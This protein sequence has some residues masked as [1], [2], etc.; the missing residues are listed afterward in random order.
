MV[1]Y[2][3]ANNKSLADAVIAVES[4]NYGTY[5][6]D[7]TTH[8]LY[9][10]FAVNTNGFLDVTDANINV[11][12]NM[13][14]QV[15]YA[16]PNLYTHNVLYTASELA[17][18]LL[19]S[20]NVPLKINLASL[21]INS[22]VTFD[23]FL[24][25]VANSMGGSVGTF[26]VVDATTGIVKT[27]TRSKDA[28][29][30]INSVIAAP[31][32]GDASDNL[33]EALPNSSGLQIAAQ[34]NELP[35]GIAAIGRDGRIVNVDDKGREVSFAYDD[36]GNTI[37]MYAFDGFSKITGKPGVTVVTGLKDGKRISTDILINGNDLG[38]D[39]SGFVSI[40]GE[41]LGYRLAGSDKLAGIVLSG[42]LKTFGDNM[43]DVID[44]VVGRQSIKNAVDDAFDTV[45]SELLANLKSAGLGA[46]SSFLTAELIHAL[47][48]GG[49]AGELTN[50]AAGTAIGTIVSNIATGA[51]L[52]SPTEL[53]AGLNPATI[54]VAVGSFLGNKLANEIYAWDT[55][56]G[57][58]GAA[59]GS[60][61]LLAMDAKFFLYAAQTGNAVIIGIAVVA[62]VLDA[63]LGNL[64]GGLI[65]SIFG[66][67]P[68]SG[69]DATWNNQQQ[70]FVVSN[71]W[72][73]KGGSEDAARNI[74]TSVAGALNSILASVGGTLL[75]PTAIQSG[76]Y[77]LIKKDF[78]YRPVGGGSDQGTVT[79]RF[80]GKDAARNLIDYGVYQGLMD[81]DF[82]IAGGDIYTKRAI[83]NYSSRNKSTNSTFNQDVLLGDIS[84]AQSYEKY[85]SNS[86]VIAA[87]IAADPNTVFATET[88][89]TL[90]RA[91][92][93]GL[94]RRAASDWFGGFS[95]LVE[96]AG[97][98]VADVSF[99]FDYDSASDQISRLIGLGQYTLRD[100]IDVAGQTT[101]EGTAVRDVLN[102]HTGSLA[103][104][105]GY[106][107][108]GH[109]NNDIAVT[110]EDFTA[111]TTSVSFAAGDLRK[112][113][114][115]AVANDGVA[116]ATEAFAASLSNA[117]GMQI[118]GGD[119]VVTVVDGTAALATLM[120]GRSY[121]WEGDGYAIFRLSLSKAASQAVTLALALADGNA[122][123][124]GVDYG[125][126]GASNIQV[127]SDGVTWTNATSLSFAVGATERFVRVAVLADNGVD[128]QGKPTNVEGNERFTLTAT[129]TAGAA[130]L[131]NGASPVSGVGTIVD[132][133]GT[134]PLVWIDD[135]TLDE[136]SGQA[137]FTLSRSRTAPSATAVS[138]ATSDRRIFGID[139]AATVD[140]GD[141][142][143]WAQASDLGDNIFGGTGNDTIYGGQL[144]DWLFGGDGNDLI[145]AGAQDGSL[146]GDG[147][148][149]DGGAGN[150]ELNGREGSDWLVGGDGSDRLNGNGGDDILAGGAGNNDILKGGDGADQY[151]VQRGDGLDII[152]DIGSDAPVSSGA[153]DAITQRMAAIE[154]WK[155]NPAAAG[156]IA[157]NWIGTAPGATAGTVTGGEDSI[158]FGAGIDIGDIRLQRSG[159]AGTPGNDLLIKIMTTDAQG[160]ETFSGTQ[161][162]VTD[163]FLNPFKRI[164]WLKFADGN[165]IRIGDITSLVIGGSGNDVLVGTAGNDFVYGGAG[166]D[167]LLLMDG[168]DVGNGGTG[169]DMVSG[170]NGRD[171]VIGGLGNDKLFGG[172]GSD[173]LT[174]DGGADQ[175]YGGA[176]RDVLSG[177][178]GDGDVVV[179][180]AGDDTFKYSRGDGRDIYFDEYANYWQTVWTSGSWNT[181][182]GFSYNTT[183]GEVMGP[184]GVA[185]YKNLGTV[186]AP[187]FDWVGLFDFNS[188]T[189]VLRY[190]NPPANAATITANAGA[191]TIEF[192]PGINLQDVILRRPAGTNDLV[193][194]ISQ[195]NAELGDT[196]SAADSVT[197]RDWYVN[198]GQIEKLAFYQTG[199]LEIAPGTRSLIA[200]SDGADGTTTAALQGTGI[201]DWITGGAGDDVIAGG[202]GNDI[203]AG[204]S[205][206]D[207]LRGE[208]GNDVLYGG[209]G[210]DQLDGGAGADV[211]VGGAG[212]DAASYA[213]ASAAVRVH[214][215]ARGANSGDAVGDEYYGIEN[216]IG[217]GGADM[218]GGDAGDNELT[219]GLGDDT[220]AGNGGDDTYIWNAGDGID[221][222]REGSFV[223][224]EVVTTAGVLAAGYQTSIWADTG[225]INGASGF[226]YWRLQI[227]GP[228]GTIVFDDSTLSYAAGATPAAPSPAS[229]NQAG[230]LGGFKRTN[231]AQ[232]TRERF[233]PAVDG[234]NDTLELGP[235]ISFSSLTF[236][237]SGNDLYITNASGQQIRLIG[238]LLAANRVETLQL[239]DG[240][241]VSLASVMIAPSAAGFYG[242]A[243]DDLIV[244]AGGTTDLSLIGGDGNDVII[245][246]AGADRLWGQNGEDI[247]E[248]GAG[249][250]RLDG[251]GRSA[252]GTVV[253]YGDTVRYVQSSA[254]VSI[255]LRINT[256]QSGGDAQGD[257][258]F[259]ISNVIGSAFDD[260]LQGDAGYNRLSGM[261]GNDTIRGG[262]ADD[263]LLGDAGD[264]TLYGDDGADALSGGLGNDNLY[265]GNGDDRL[266]GG[267]GADNLYGDAGKDTL[268]AGAGDDLL[269]GGTGDDTLVGAAGNDTLVGGDGN[270]MLSGGTGND[271]LSGGLGNDNYLFDATSG[272]DVIVDASGTNLINF[273]QSVSYDRL[274]ITRSGTDLRIAVMGGDTI[275]TLSG[276]YAAT[277][278]GLARAIQTST[279]A[280][281]LDNAN[282]LNLVTAMT[283]QATATPAAMPQAITDLLATYW[284]AGGKAAPTAPST[285]RAVA[286]SE[287]TAIAISGGAY[288]VIDHD[289]GPITYS[290]KADAGPSRGTVTALNAAT[291]AV[292]YTPNANVNGSD[293]FS[294]I[295]TDA[296]GQSVEL[297]VTV[298]IAPVNDL[299][300]AV[301]LQSGALSI[302][303]GGVGSTTG[304]GTAVAQFQSSDVDGDPLTFSLADDAGGRFQISG[305]GALSVKTA[306]SL[307]YEAG[308][309]HSIVI[310]VSDGNGGVTQTGFTIAVTNLNEPLTLPA[311]YSLAVNENVAV[312]TTLGTIVAS[313][314][315]ASSTA[316]GQPRYFFLVG[317]TASAVSSDGRYTIDAVSGV[318][319]TY[320]AIDFE[321]GPASVVHTVIARDNAGNAPFNQTS[322]AVTIGVTN[323]NE[324]NA[325]PASYAMA[326]NENVAIGTVV[327]TVTATDLD[328]TSHVFG[329]QRYYFLNGTTAVSTTADGRYVIDASTGVIKTYAG[330][331]YEAGMP[332]VAYTVIARDNAGNAPFNQASSTVAIGITNQNEAN[333]LPT[334]YAMG[335]NENVAVGTAVG[336]VAATDPDDAAITFGQQ[337]YYFLNGTT[338]SA[339]SSDNR[340][341]IDASTGI[342]KTNS[343]LNYEAG[344]T[345]VAYTVIARD[346]AGNA[347]YYQASSTVTIGIADVNEAPTAMA[348][349]PTAIS[350]AER[351]RIAAGVTRDAIDLTTFTVTDPDAASTPFSTYTYAVSDSRFEFVG[352]I[353]RLKLNA[354]LDYEAASSVVVT[355]TATDTSP[356]HLA[357]ARSVTI[358][359]TNIDDILEGDDNANTLT[360]QKNRDII[361]GYGGNDVIDGGDGY[362]TIYG[363]AGS[364]IIYSGAGTGS[365]L[366]GEDDNDILVGGVGVDYLLGGNNNTGTYDR[367]YGGAGNDFLYGG[368]G[369]DILVGGEGADLLD[370]GNGIDYADY[371]QIGYGVQATEG[372]SVDLAGIVAN[373]GVAVGDTFVGIEFLRGTAFDDALRG[374]AVREL[375][376]G[377][378][379]NDFIDARAGDD[380]LYGGAGND[381]LYG[382]DG[383]DYIR[384]DDGDDV[385][386]GGN[387]NDTL[388]GGAGNDT[389]YAESGNDLLDGG[390]GDDILVGGLDSDTYL[391]SR[392]SGAD[393][394]QNYDPSGTDVDVLGFQDT[395]GVINDKDIWFE[396]SGNDLL[397]SVIGTTSSARIQNWYVTPGID[398]ANYK[399]DYIIAGTR[400]SRTIDV[401]GLVA[402]MATKTKPTTIADQDALLADT[403][404]KAVWATYWRTNAAPTLAA[405]ATQTMAEDGTLVLTVS[406]T[407]DITPAPGIQVSGEILSGGNVIPVSGLVFGAPDNAGNRTLTIRPASNVAGSA[408]IRIRAVDAGGVAS[409]RDFNLSVTPVAD[410]PTIASFVGGQGTSGAPVALTVNV[411]FPDADG[412]ELQELWITGVPTGVT[413]SA[414]T[415][416]SATATWKLTPVQASNLK[417]N[418]PAGWSTD[419]SLTLKARATEG[420]Q[421][422]VATATTTVVLN[423]P[424]TSLSLTGSVNENVANGTAVGMVS[425]VDPDGDV[426]TY[427]LL[428][429][430]GGRF[431]L[432]GAGALTVANGT[433]LNFEAA[434]SHSITVRA[435][436]RFGAIRDQSLTVTVNNV[437]E[438]PY[439]TGF[440]GGGTVAANG[441]ILFTETG[442]GAMP[443]NAD[444]LVAT[445]A[446][447][448]PDGTTPTLEFANNPNNWFYIS[449]NTVRFKP[450][451]NFDYETLINYF[452]PNA[453]QDG[454]GSIDA[455]LG[456]L[457]VRATDGALRATGVLI[458][459]YISNVNE[460]PNVP[461]GPG[462]VYFDETGLGSNP[463]NAGTLLG[464]Y[465][466]LSDPDGTVPTLQLT[467]NLGNWFYL[468]GNSVRFNGG[469][470]FDFEWFRANNYSVNDWNGDGRQ[471]VYLGDV[472]VKAS[473]GTLMSGEKRTQVFISNVNEAPNAPNYGATTWSFADET[474]LGSNPANGGVT[475]ATFSMTDPDGS[476]PVLEFADPS[477][478]GWFNIVGNQVRFNA[479]PNFDFEWF[480]ANNYGIYDWN[481]DGRLDAHIADVRLRSNDGS[482]LS[483]ETLLQVFISDVNERPNAPVME[484]NNIFQETTGGESHSERL[485]TRFGL[486]D[487]DGPTPSLVI[488]SGNDWGWFRVNGQH[489]QIN[490]GVNW[491]ADWLRANKGQHG[492]DADFYTD[493]NG[494]G[495]KEIRVATL[496]VATQDASGALSDPFT[497]N[498]LIED[499]NEAPNWATTPFTFNLNENPG[500]YQQVGTVW[501]SDIDGPTS[502]LRY[503]FSNWDRYLDG[504]LN[505][506]V[507]RSTDQIYVMTESGVV[508][509]NGN[510]AMDYDAA[511]AQRNFSYET[512]I[513]DKAYGANNAYSYGTLNINLQDVNEGHWLNN[514]SVAVN[515]VGSLPPLQP[516]GDLNSGQTIDLNAMMLSDPEARP[517]TMSW[518]FA[519]NSLDS[520]NWHISPQGQLSLRYGSVDYETLASQGQTSVVLG[521]KASDGQNAATGS[522]T[523]NVRDVNEAPWLS[524]GGL[525]T[526]SYTVYDPYMGTPMGV[527]Y[528]T[529]FH[530]DVHDPDST[531]GYS[532]PYNITYNNASAYGSP[533]ATQMG[534]A[535][536]A[537]SVKGT[538]SWG[539][540]AYYN[541]PTPLQVTSGGDY[542][543]YGYYPHVKTTLY[544]QDA[545]GA[546][547]SLNVDLRASNYN[548]P[549]VILDL[550]GDGV[551]LTNWQQTS[552]RFDMNND[553]KR[554]LTSWAGPDDALLGIDLNGNGLID[555]GSEI[556]FQPHLDG[557]LSDLE[558]LRLYDTNANGFIDAGDERFADFRVWQDVNQDGISAPGE[559]KALSEAGIAEINLT[560]T[561]TGNLP[562]G[563]SFEN[564][565]YSTSQYVKT[566]GTIGTIG[567]AF[568]SY[569]ADGES[570]FIHGDHNS[571]IGIDLDGNGLAISDLG[572]SDVAFDIG[573]GGYPLGT[574]W[575]GSGDALLVA[576]VNGNGT[577]DNGI[578]LAVGGQGFSLARL[579]ALDSNHD[580]KV[581]AADDAFA[582]LRLWEDA[583]QDGVSQSGELKTLSETDITALHLPS[584]AT[585]FVLGLGE[586]RSYNSFTVEFGGGSTRQGAELLLAYNSPFASQASQLAQAM[587]VFAPSAGSDGS[588]SVPSPINDPYHLAASAA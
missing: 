577:I 293:S 566:D 355:V 487:P 396:R 80:S 371:S 433:L 281:Y 104:Q 352:N 426:L 321:A 191:D 205:G 448:D 248:G 47:S 473:D 410:M 496:T 207:I 501:G 272:N 177:G 273:D 397:V 212:Q 146:G 451:M 514:R 268:T 346:N 471:E 241:S 403:T 2:A 28:T 423:A 183:T 558:G 24:G 574:A 459:T 359:V 172:A 32:I 167:K 274:W 1:A 127:S 103:D 476:T 409:V 112:Q 38:I 388:L 58:I 312:G 113:V 315:D 157:P 68:R 576:D 484:A 402:L 382:G 128:G 564:V 493:V 440:T 247:L 238:Q 282:S 279:H 407:D 483:G 223:V 289:G 364:D 467:G 490:T 139:V 12:G 295:A 5:L 33:I 541:W 21:S 36:Y 519:D 98:T 111:L 583:N 367:L 307:N 193:L 7:K 3:K 349:T 518:S 46:V 304:T 345:S 453:D 239:A 254:A 101:I 276:F 231:G 49:M 581:T 138:F 358:N 265:G 4:S 179:G 34:E 439:I 567:D 464:T 366:Y 67:T 469:L 260:V 137:K 326:V 536:G 8:N 66:G 504:N 313:D 322:T 344:N 275:V 428:D 228:D 72:S 553:G 547:G 458:K 225:T 278:A 331:N 190:F 338:A 217:S 394:I 503:T 199:I 456:D 52:V 290:L 158:V 73:R 434:Q 384:G 475:V 99:G 255:D 226:H 310:R 204:N 151:L 262:G 568:L 303:E 294:L 22:A 532:S 263:V 85:L 296:D 91:Q 559:L 169:D 399:L 370:G 408:T 491:T 178:R 195:E 108:N 123:G 148:Y 135:V 161:L 84:S 18:L 302:L 389:L 513:Y 317:S 318:I 432:T 447:F 323:L 377:G 170:D 6:V 300:T 298:S 580:G 283:A 95:F 488:L 405:I 222:I 383:A 435:T 109:L 362:D 218:L 208:A 347:G 550:D 17:I 122:T 351:D 357:I 341:I 219:G 221:T 119:A 361:Y 65:G 462:A 246:T 116:E 350:V 372:V 203:I 185:I 29:G 533:T 573:G 544:A 37:A 498:V 114:T 186:Q 376:E 500:W 427:A 74:A 537:P 505:Q 365:V 132:G 337:R 197:I 189:G 450:G 465:G 449:G 523:V 224:E 30:K 93:L 308:T 526:Y 188:A 107:V 23:A 269:D 86:A 258:L 164:E 520:G 454:N 401:D 542:L 563:E 252:Y 412:S 57:Q 70:Q 354:S 106:T 572:D 235:G 441:A 44:G 182:G 184:G 413:L 546:T 391:M 69:A 48:I 100:T 211:L 102:L 540:P 534:W 380:S 457:W 53:F 216:L 63:L 481:G 571:A 232:V 210:N 51:S 250:D 369:D 436:D 424:P 368:D 129:V 14:R 561:P 549:P 271:S 143:D 569:M 393:T 61:V 578:E 94:T 237:I 328:G 126:A 480:R 342:I 529:W 438:A 575:I 144:D 201:A 429:N 236:S 71:V 154:A 584:A 478:A 124:G 174:G 256:E 585:P 234:G 309:S 54:G 334:S 140:L 56:G 538:D 406:A 147:N 266:D 417:V 64:I 13:D 181:A 390:E 230:W 60:S 443:A 416:D 579:A 229:Y 333:A 285:P 379:G 257:T 77:G 110:G 117:P 404:Y 125:S 415:F 510:Q 142:D 131:A 31:A 153:G 463:A 557:A 168:D 166:N 150:D 43:G 444:V 316:F 460:A 27:I 420:G 267:D 259:N 305:S 543:V 327:G 10:Q 477:V 16:M 81:P 509:V 11:A 482:I 442:L 515:E 311:S 291:G 466:G 472:V 90:T 299:P 200:G 320:A 421:T 245:G 539:M 414:G 425:G 446:A 524:N 339:T 545:G 360:G 76:S 512:L 240:Q 411:S 253:N 105:R 118:M 242:S 25:Q 492:T 363:G 395:S 506:W 301:T 400:Y 26:R 244:G 452:P 175:I 336:T 386:Y 560:L 378:A 20:S 485:Q 494:N 385:I 431:A 422:V 50:A 115:V 495:L 89:I 325:L 455:Y 55:V 82:Q 292:T 445:I 220:L 551:E 489:I 180:G 507:S 270:D 156:A 280:F 319:K 437:N 155:A 194:A 162:T 521:V 75:N 249:A 88:L 517:W 62:A 527:L 192:A 159:V 586:S 387:G 343:A 535:S 171:L 479:G 92:E 152:E 373:T 588:T 528:E 392:T 215:T 41:Q 582:S 145:N 35:D 15:Q 163:W 264:D 587:T 570:N 78:V 486:S 209:A 243:G 59:V 555:D 340:Y 461:T 214:L 353:L 286:T 556:S 332:S 87:L 548:G 42:A 470:N 198:P 202:G 251:G 516:L 213:S 297:K 430:A 45:G 288:G 474:G 531:A 381:T 508:Y 227:K 335:V 130:A 121:A 176:D 374:T 173:A 525:T 348:W 330:L 562:D 552:V 141:G 375:I 287:D 83:Y 165:E 284:H 97:T 419:L 39:F 565:I 261:A 497:Y 329:Q 356:A 324:A 233:D 511:G 149:L 468:D 96:E 530:F 306:T 136:A 499:K 502:E 277:G 196:G 314:P 554:D 40:L 160:V 206:F 522:L 19:H 134:E 9:S 120:V 187:N 418:A 133:P 79:Q 398:G